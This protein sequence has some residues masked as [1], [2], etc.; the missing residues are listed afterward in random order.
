MPERQGWKAEGV[1]AASQ[2]IALS[3]VVLVYLRKEAELE[4]NTELDENQEELIIAAQQL[5]EGL[6]LARKQREIIEMARKVSAFTG[7]HGWKPMFNAMDELKAAIRHADGV[8]ANVADSGAQIDLE[9]GNTQVEL[10]AVN[11][12]AS[13]DDAN[14]LF[15][16]G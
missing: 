5:H 6:E 13:E 9:S 11:D 16:T 8:Q 14:R 1:A 4:T 10:S 2:I 3:K 12:D 15:C 7:H